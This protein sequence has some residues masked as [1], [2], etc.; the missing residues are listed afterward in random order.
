MS[1]KRQKDI[2]NQIKE[3]TTL[4]RQKVRIGRTP[5]IENAWKVFECVRSQ[6]HRVEPVLEVEY[7]NE[8]GS[9]LGPTLEFYALVAQAFKDSTSPRLFLE[10]PNGL[11]FPQAYH[12]D[13]QKVAPTLLAKPKKDTRAN[14]PAGSAFAS[15]SGLLRAGRAHNSSE[16]TAPER[17][18]RHPL[19]RTFE[20]KL[21]KHFKLLGM[22]VAKSLTDQRLMDLRLHPV[23][24]R[25]V[26]SDAAR[27]VDVKR[28]RPGGGGHFPILC[29]FTDE[30]NKDEEEDEKKGMEARVTLSYEADIMQVSPSFYNQLQKMKEMKAQGFDLEQLCV[31]FT[32]PGPE[33]LYELR[34]GGRDMVVTRDTLDEYLQLVGRAMLYS[35]IALQVHAFREGFELF[36]PLEALLSFQPV[37]LATQ[38]IAGG[39]AADNQYWTLDHLKTYIKPA[40]GY[41]RDSAPFRYLL[42]VLSELSPKERRLFCQFATGAP[43]LPLEG[44]GA[45]KPLL[46][47]VVK[48]TPSPQSPDRNL[49]S[50]MTCTNYL[51]LPRFTSKDVMRERLLVAINEGQGSFLLS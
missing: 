48:E 46:T 18:E 8:S 22:L 21:Y 41:Q 44:F 47:V 42:E 25:L 4:P 43:A 38:L 9:G 24:W 45:L 1:R 27:E 19:E 33:P 5:I 50:V 28:Q 23:F 40:H 11:L 34:D 13:F 15:R 16:W 20:S 37:E 2:L 3:H 17:D 39:D 29:P 32:V 26:L 14:G 35:G 49:P 12:V 10:P 51:K 6:R 36:L 31:I 30:P 7:Y